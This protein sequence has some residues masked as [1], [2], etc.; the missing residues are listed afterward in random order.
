MGSATHEDGAEGVAVNTAQ[1]R[2]SDTTRRRRA[3]GTVRIWLRRRW[4]GLRGLLHRMLRSRGRSRTR[5]GID[6]RRRWRASRPW[7][8]VAKGVSLAGAALLLTLIAFS[9]YAVIH[10]KPSGDLAYADAS[11]DKTNFSCSVLA[12]TLG[13]LLSLALASA[14]FLLVRLWVVGRPYMRKAR[15]E[16]H[17]VVQTAGSMIGKVVGR[18][19]LC[20]VIIED[21]RD[22]AIR[23]PHVVVGGVGT[24]KTALLVRLTQ[25]LA[26]RGAVPVPI[27]LRDAQDSLDFRL[28][29][30]KRFVAD[31][32]TRLLSDT[33][34][35]K[36]WRELCKNDQVVVLADGLEE[37]LI[38]GNAQKERDNLIRL[39][40]RQ[41]NE[42]RLP[43]IV[44]SRPH[45]PLRDMEAAIV[46]L[47]PLSEE[48]ALEYVQQLETGEDSRRLDW[49]V[50]TADVAE[51]PL[52]LQ[53]TRQL[54]R[55]GLMDSVTRRQSDRGLDTRSVDRAQLRLRLLD[56][57]MQA[58]IDG[59]FTPGLALTR[60]DRQAT[61]EQLSLLACIGLRWDRLQV[62]FDQAEAQ[63]DPQPEILTE[64]REKLGKLK[65]RYDLRLAATWGTQL[66]LVEA[67]GDG[68]RFPHSIMQAYLASRLIDIAMADSEFREQAL[69]KSGRE[70]LLAL[71]MYS[72]AR[73]QSPRP[74]GTARISFW[75]AQLGT[76]K[77]TLQGM[78]CDEAR[79]RTDVKALDLYAAA[80][81]IDCVCQQPMHDDIASKL[82][83]SWPDIWARDQRTLEEAKLNAVRRFGESA[84]M[85]SEQ[86]RLHRDYPAE[87]AYLRLYRI[88][89]A[90]PSYPIRLAS[91]QEIGIGSDQAFDALAGHLRPPALTDSAGTPRLP[92][93][94]WPLRRPHL[95][96][97]NPG[98]EADQEHEDRAWEEAVIGAWLAPLLVGSVTEPNSS[99]ASK[100][101]DD[102]L[103][104]L[105]ERPGTRAES[106][107]R[108]SLEVALAQ[109]FKHAANRRRRHPHTRPEAR[110][111]LAER[112][113]EMLRE[114]HFWFTRLTLV[115]A[116]C[117]WALP[118][119]PPGQQDQRDDD[120]RAL[121][122]NWIA[123]PGNRP[124]H[125]FVVEAS[126][127]AVQALET[128]QPERFIWIDESGV[129]A[130]IGSR[131]ANPRAPRKHNLWVPPSTGWTALHPRAQQLVA[132]V[133]LLLN[134]AE[135]G[136]RPS[137]RNRRLHRT[138]QDELPPC[139]HGERSPL[140]PTRTVGM[141][142]T[143]EPGS[144]CKRGCNFG[145][146][147]YP[148]KGEAS[149]RVELSEAFCRRQQVLVGVGSIRRRPAPWQVTLAGDLKQ[150]WKQMGQRAQSSVLDRHQATTR[151][152]KRA[153]HATEPG[154]AGPS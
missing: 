19:E 130:R 49:V 70:F 38:E 124:E 97:G 48:A 16:S 36:V 35:E 14:L 71:V 137:E 64:V 126:K 148:P 32:N 117:L 9:I 61:L 66:G 85:I 56:T 139:L 135:R 95:R 55:S 123:L 17:N 82:E 74:D 125:P 153:Q 45:D 51:T 58:L 112:A 11:C 31:T 131:P 7:V 93:R 27:R 20:N 53:I 41:A 86:R 133:L 122:K 60:E 69:S 141:A 30:R 107:L 83:K 142:E 65:R 81:Q 3:P 39:A 46:E 149:Y 98:P 102:W 90:E 75:A 15:D 114:S 118:D 143:S 94:Q 113:R 68:V 5:R 25:L 121:I 111:Y 40:I 91:V 128:G 23:R 129:A 150:F 151:R 42:Q 138:D 59:H 54:H 84:R 103:Q 87:P 120:Q 105:G 24:G 136:A 154:R 116:L 43:L 127:L 6:E 67:R 1:N 2:S 76:D 29:A 104:Y 132:D 13:P 140:D 8:R 147:P 145:L 57:W 119:G 89:C 50:E 99:A 73:P 144:N 10:G 47:E 21:L 152:V 77:R 101:L 37:A 88:A 100:N 80:L 110:A 72:R 12:G 109:G 28:L 62:T 115:H 96:W 18:D 22:P 63:T 79:R 44:A 92:L 33:E 146:C 26:E 52:Y 108:L 134:L 106:D 4:D 34:G 78:L